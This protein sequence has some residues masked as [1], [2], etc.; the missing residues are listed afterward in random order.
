MEKV[1][2]TSLKENLL[3]E[4]QGS[5]FA[6]KS[7]P[8]SIYVHVRRSMEITFK[9]I[10]EQFKE[11]IKIDK[12]HITLNDI[13]K[14]VTKIMKNKNY[15]YQPILDIINSKQ[16]EYMSK[17]KFKDY[18]HNV[19]NDANKNIHFTLYEGNSNLEIDSKKALD[20]FVKNTAIISILIDEFN[21]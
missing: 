9:Y 16:R 13:I 7:H 2:N 15:L 10:F 8:G 14:E 19:K 11:N 4:F 17:Q 6:I 12:E 20:L 5:L 18:V 3:N 21:L 1:K